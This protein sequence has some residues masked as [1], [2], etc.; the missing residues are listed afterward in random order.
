MPEL[1][2]VESAARSESRRSLI[3]DDEILSWVSVVNSAMA[4]SVSS[5]SGACWK[6]VKMPCSIQL[7][8]ALIA[9]FLADPASKN[10]V[11]ARVAR[12]AFPL[13]RSHL[14]W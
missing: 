10:P 6:D 7:K 13:F 11:F 1:P 8:I 14:F 4:E 5:G 3:D 2:E 9:F 12:P